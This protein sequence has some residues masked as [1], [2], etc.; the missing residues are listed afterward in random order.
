MSTT[1]R[2]WWGKTIRT[3]GSHFYPTIKQNPLSWDVPIYRMATGVCVSCGHEYQAGAGHEIDIVRQWPDPH[4][5]PKAG[6]DCEACRN[7]KGWRKLYRH[8]LASYEAK[9][10]PRDTQKELTWWVGG[11]VLFVIGMML[12][13]LKAMGEL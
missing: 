8:R 10:K 11:F 3:K 12:L 9:M 4:I 1:H 7:S 13:T 2:T 5:K 6:Q